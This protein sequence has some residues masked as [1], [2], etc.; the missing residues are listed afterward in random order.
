MNEEKLYHLLGQTLRAC[1]ETHEPP[2]TQGQLA[3]L[4]KL[5][6]SSIS[7]IENGQQRVPLHTLYNLC[8]ALD[9]QP[10]DV[11]PMLS[12]VQDSTENQERQLPA[13]A[14]EALNKIIG[15]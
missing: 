14:A 12:S 6:R 4:V 15:A 3:D 5:E 10:H 8:I 9:V 1:R 11:L 13:L 7:N 2:Y